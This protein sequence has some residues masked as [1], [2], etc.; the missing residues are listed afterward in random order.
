MN[1]YPHDREAFTQGLVIE[2]GVL[3]EGTGLYGES[4]LRRVNMQTGV[5]EQSVPLPAEVFGEG[6]TVFGDQLIQL[7][8][9]SQIGYVYDAQ[10]FQLERTFSYP[11]EGWGLTD[12]GSQLF[13]S[14]G[15]AT[16]RM[17]DPVT[18]EE[19]GRL[20]VTDVTGPVTMLNEL[21]FIRGEIWANVWQTD[22]IVRIDP[23]TG[24]V[25]G[26]IDLTGLLSQEERAQGADVLNGIA[27]DQ[28]TERV[29]V[30]GKLWPKLFEIE[31]IAQPAPG[32][33]MREQLW[34]PIN[35]S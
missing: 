21:E 27:Y 7:T 26:W 5:V 25:L 2:N 19:R 11:G 20:D 24:S 18:F 33:G 1:T 31:L 14:D 16:L 3:Y 10:T 28:V 30:T 32:T 12:D 8:W 23:Q 22:H 35:F 29:F 15:T 34:L 4:T 9:Q 13:M 6:V 17:L